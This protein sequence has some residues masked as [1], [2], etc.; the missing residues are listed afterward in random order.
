MSEVHQSDEFYLRQKKIAELREKGVEPYGDKYEV[1]HQAGAVI[2]NFAELGDSS[3]SVSGRILSKRGHGKAAFAHILDMSGKIQIYIRQDR[4][5]E[6]NYNL[7]KSLDI[8]DIIGA[9]GEVFKTKT[10][11][12]TINIS[13]FNLLSKSLRP[14][15]EKWHGLKDVDL[16]YRQRYVDLIVN[17]AV[18]EVFITRSK[19]IQAIREYL[20]RK[21]F[22]EVET[23]VM[24]GVAG[25]PAPGRLLPITTRL[26]L[27]F[28]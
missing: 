21:D 5:G 22:L 18:R 9:T 14:L 3:V 24:H 6:E 10:G 2:Q 26:I 1:T 11:E 20:T 19:A 13:S 25:V 23:P 4:V 17:P 7:Y 16:R 27:I 8:G 15:P 12:V 28:T